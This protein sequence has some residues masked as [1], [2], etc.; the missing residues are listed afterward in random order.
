MV[1]GYHSNSS[2]NRQ[3]CEQAGSAA[4]RSAL[5]KSPR[6]ES[7]LTRQRCSQ[8]LSWVIPSNQALR[9]QL[10]SGLVMQ[11]IR[12]NDVTRTMI[13]T[14]KKFN[15]RSRYVPLFRKS[16]V[17]YANT[18]LSTSN[19]TPA[20]S[21]TDTHGYVFIFSRSLIT[22]FASLPRQATTFNFP[23]RISRHIYWARRRHEDIT[24]GTNKIG[25]ARAT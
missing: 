2:A 19:V 12:L 3:N 25:K 17:S 14:K 6:L 15:K 9:C 10:Q 1:A 16:N 22:S 11:I 21:D 4:I 7:M 8:V 23:S 20:F 13:M 5:S 18:D 24:T